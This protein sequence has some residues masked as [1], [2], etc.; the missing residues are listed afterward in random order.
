[1]ESATGSSLPR[2]LCGI[3]PPM[4][5]P[6][7][8]RDTL[9][10]AGLERLVEHLIG[11]GVHGLFILGTSG[12][13]PSLSYRLRRELIARV[14]RQAGDR[15][16]VLVGVTDTSVKETLDLAGCAAE[17]GAHGVVLAPPYYFP[18]SQAELIRY[19]RRVV[20]EL[21]LPLMLYNIPKMTKVSFE[22]ETVRQLLDE[23]RIVGLKDSSR[24]MDYFVAVRRLTRQRP[25]WSLLVGYEHMLVDTLHAGGDGGVL[26]GANLSP[27]LFVELYQAVTTDCRERVDQIQQTLAVLRR[28]YSVGDG[29]LAAVA[30]IKCALSLRGIAEDTMVEPF[31]RLGAEQRRQVEAILHE[32]DVRQ[33]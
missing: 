10:L 8:D 11:G 31:E 27:R 30:G 24:E 9:D 5:T 21:P 16:T 13:T 6:L 12:E 17:A 32:A 29:T 28:I 25:D 1:M 14:C 3:V 2:A 20:A 4:V 22:P 23:P 7:K 15:L 19:V 18:V 33:P 26:A